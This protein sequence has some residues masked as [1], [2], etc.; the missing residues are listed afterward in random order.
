[1]FMA[2]ARTAADAAERERAVLV[3]RQALAAVEAYAAEHR[4]GGGELDFGMNVGS[5]PARVEGRA[6][7]RL[8]AEL[9]YW[10]Y[11]CQIDRDPGWYA[12]AGDSGGLYR[13]TISVEH[14]SGGRTR[15]VLRVKTLLGD[16]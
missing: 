1:M 15:E 3:A 14:E 12:P 13:V 4:A 9:A 10:G 2:G 5:R 16:R 7:G 11:R 6:A 8:A